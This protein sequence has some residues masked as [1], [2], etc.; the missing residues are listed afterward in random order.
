MKIKDEFILRK[1]PGMNLVMPAGRNVKS[2]NGLLMLNDTGAFIFE[3]LQTGSTPEETAQ[4]LTRE[5]DVALDVA[6]KDVQNTINVLIEGAPVEG[7]PECVCE[8]VADRTLPVGTY[9]ITVLPGTVTTQGVELKDGVFTI[10]PAPL[11]ITAKSYT[12][13]V[14]QPNPTFEVSYK[15]FRNGEKE[16]VVTVKPVVSC[17]ASETSPAGTYAITPSGAEAANYTMNYVAGVLTV[18]DPTAVSAP[19][20]DDGQR[21]TEIYDLQGRRTTQPRRGIYVQGRRKTYKR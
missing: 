20:A 21:Q 12:R 2:F 13:Q 10:E 6:S 4:A 15:G 14:G 17:E 8:A 9:P 5:Y 3:R 1:V 19:T 16:E 11:T 7:T 18:E